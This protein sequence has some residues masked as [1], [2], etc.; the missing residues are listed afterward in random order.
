MGTLVL[1][2]QGSGKTSY[3]AKAL[4]DRAIRYP[5]HPI[6]V[7]DWS[8]SITDT[9]LEIA[10]S[11]PPETREKLLK[12][13]VYDELGNKEWVIPLPEF[14]HIYGASYEEQVQ[15]VSQNLRKLSDHLVEKAPVLG[16]AAVGNRHTVF[17]VITAITTDRRKH[18][19]S[20]PND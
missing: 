11:Q 8:G 6:F 2:S 18:G 19:R 3:V 16:G 14:S 13:I 12:R 10:L 15:R 17:R 7:L 4:V 1:G 20:L 5:D 9:F